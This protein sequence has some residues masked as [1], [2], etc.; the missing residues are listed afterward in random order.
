MFK[1]FILSLLDILS[2]ELY[3]KYLL[4]LFLTP[5]KSTINNEIY[6]TTCH[7][8]LIHIGSNHWIKTYSWGKGSKTVLLAHDWSANGSN[9][10]KFVTPLLEKNYRVI[11]FDAPAHGLS[12][13][14]TCD[15]FQYADVL[16][17]LSL[18]YAT[19]YIIA[20][21]FGAECSLVFLD[22]FKFK[23]K[24]LVTI[25]CVS[26]FED[27]TNNFGKTLNIKASQIRKMEKLLE[28]TYSDTWQVKDLSAKKI[29]QNLDI[30]MLFVHDIDDKALNK[31]INY[32]NILEE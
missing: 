29:I 23:L 12:S 27:R 3:T 1:R 31:I 18:K 11:A 14:K 22:T 6:K 5:Q 9:M 28:S 30:P 20:H 15:I 8:D 17:V 24:G 7:Y 21:S 2:Q 10:S 26:N 32:I 16:N 19:K 4:H 13:G 25:G